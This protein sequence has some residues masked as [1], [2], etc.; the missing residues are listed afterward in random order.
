MH[1]SVKGFDD[2]VHAAKHPLQAPD[3]AV[4]LSSKAA[5]AEGGDGI[6]HLAYQAHNVLS[7][8]WGHFVLQLAQ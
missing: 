5:L 8:L 7:Y 2:D 1:C 3:R 4:L 6:A